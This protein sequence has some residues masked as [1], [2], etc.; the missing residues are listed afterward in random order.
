VNFG[1]LRKNDLDLRPITL[2]F[3]GVLE[4]VEVQGYAKLYQAKCNSSWVI[5]ST[6]FL[7]YLAMVKNPKIQF[8]DLA[9]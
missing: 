3:N 6:N 4:V 5:E 9:I 2:K 7:P 8:C 1:P